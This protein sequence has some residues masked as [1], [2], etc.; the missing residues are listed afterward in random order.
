MSGLVQFEPI[1][2][3]GQ[4]YIQSSSSIMP[5]CLA[6][7]FMLF[8]F[9]I[10][11]FVNYLCSLGWLTFVLLFGAW[12]YGSVFSNTGTVRGFFGYHMD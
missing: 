12:I 8:I 6:K 4:L 10:P 2:F 11:L 1:L 7:L 5:S 9:L 3:K